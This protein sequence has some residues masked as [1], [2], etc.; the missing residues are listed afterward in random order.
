MSYQADILTALNASEPITDLVGT[1]IHADFA[2]LDTDPPYL[3]YQVISTAGETTHSGSRE[4]E[5]PLIQFSAWANGKA[6]VIG[7]ARAVGKALEGEDIGGASGVV[8]T[9]AGQ[10]GEHDPQTNLF[11]EIL[12][13]RGHCNRN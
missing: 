3:V 6:E 8:L 7:L 9:F 2:P 5:F 12:E 4:I 11:G 10:H 1:R 13:F